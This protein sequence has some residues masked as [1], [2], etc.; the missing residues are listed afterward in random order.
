MR[1][2]PHEDRRLG[3]RRLEPLAG[4]W[5][6]ETFLALPSARGGEPL[7]ARYLAGA[8][9]G[10]QA[11]SIQAALLRQ[12]RGLLP[13]PDVHGAYDDGP[14]PG[15]LLTELLPGERGD[16]VLE[17]MV[18]PGRRDDGR[19]RTLG[20][21]LGGVAGT[22]AGVRMPEAGL[23]VDESLRIEPF[24]LRLPGWVDDHAAGLVAAGWSAAETAALRAVADRAAPA[25]EG[26]APCLVHSDLNPKNVLV[27]PA[28]LSVTGVLD[29]EFAHAG[30]PATDLGN[31]LR[32]EREPAYVD[33]VLDGWCTP[34][35]RATGTR[36]DPDAAT[37]T[38][39][40]ADLVALVELAART[41][42]TP[43]VR[44][45]RRHLRAIAATG[46]LH[47]TP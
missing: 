28:E 4:G 5:S 36:P 30:H 40:A 29:W 20:R 9:H 33:G 21:A 35:G 31:L 11:A 38:A 7:V 27:D 3:G 13:V 45:A 25:L 8:H 37:D 42:T 43:V 41:V 1:H 10:P 22:L 34:V 46:D 19:L 47:A 16:L 15:L 44:R 2:T 12:V 6:G 32:F 14:V 23:F 39:R 18:R 17:R 24:R 26:A